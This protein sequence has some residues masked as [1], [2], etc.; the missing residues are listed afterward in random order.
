MHLFSADAKVFSKKNKKILP[1]K[2]WKKHPQ[3]LLI[4]GPDQ[5][6]SQ[7]LFHKNLPP[8]DFSIMTLVKTITKK[9]N[10][11][12]SRF[13]SWT[14]VP[15]N[16]MNL[17]KVRTIL[18]LWLESARLQQIYQ[19]STVIRVMMQDWMNTKQVDEKSPLAKVFFTPTYWYLLVLSKR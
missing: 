16:A 19:A 17:K 2:I 1:L 11:F 14:T 9:L 12:T 3:K 10:Y 4:I 18:L 15:C 8:R 5:P 7:F 6:K 13:R